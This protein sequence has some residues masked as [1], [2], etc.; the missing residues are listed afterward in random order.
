[1]SPVPRVV[2]YALILAILIFPLPLPPRSSAT[3]T[4]GVNGIAIPVLVYHRFGPT[5]TDSMTVTTSVLVSHLEYLR[6][7]GYVVIPLGQFVAYRLGDGPPPPPRAV[8]ITVDDAHRSVYTHLFPLVRQYRMPVTLFVYP[9]AISNAPYAMTWEQL[10]ELQAS[11]FFDIQ[12]HSYWHPNF[13][14]EKKRLSHQRYEQLVEMQLTKS[15][16]TLEK[17]LSTHVNV[18]AWPFGIYDDELMRKAA[19]AGY[20]AALTLDRRHARESD[21]PFALPRYLMTDRDRGKVFERLITGGE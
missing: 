1:M 21:P 10:R 5:V 20:V 2:L 17:N 8:V 15:K 19:E 3:E 4:L 18:L 13:K 12:S 9:S 11:G 16:A 7:N 14:I 6:E